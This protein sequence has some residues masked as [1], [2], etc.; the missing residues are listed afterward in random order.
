MSSIAA[1]SARQRVL[2]VACDLF[3]RQGIRSVGIDTI[4]EKSGVAKTTLYRHFPTKES[5]IIAYLEEH[6]QINWETFDKVLANH[7]GSPKE[8][9]L[10]FIDAT[11]EILEPE[12][13]RGCAFLNALAEFSEE[14]HPVHLI[15]IEYNRALR[16]RLARLSKQA[17]AEDDRLTD[18][19]MLL[20]NGAMASIPVYGFTGPT[21]ELK[22]IATQLIESHL[23]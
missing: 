17:G 10:A 5:L 7:N 9:L 4:V 1:S 8:Q 12:H 13:H 20:I 16:K 3:Y 14:N 2:E 19:L 23:D 15:A 22:T 21:S 18:Q 6:D 11:I